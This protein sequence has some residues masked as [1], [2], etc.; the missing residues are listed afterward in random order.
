MGL[1]SGQPFGL[2]GMDRDGN[3][4]A[5]AMDDFRDA[6]RRAA[7]HS[8][9]GRLIDFKFSHIMGSTVPSHRAGRRLSNKVQRRSS[10]H[11]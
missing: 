10:L 11:R 5:A 7:I 9:L 3:Q 2:D 6:R 4:L 1:I 8:V